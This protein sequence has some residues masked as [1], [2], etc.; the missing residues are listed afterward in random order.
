MPILY[1][2]K[3]IIRVLETHGFF[4]SQKGS[5]VK[6]KTTV[7]P[8]RPVIIPANRKVIPFGTFRSIVRQSGLTESDFLFVHEV[9]EVNF[10]NSGREWFGEALTIESKSFEVSI[11]LGSEAYC[12]NFSFR[13][14]SASLAISGPPG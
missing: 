13:A 8:I 1:S 4:V 10:R 6:M 11:G 3:Q 12:G 9:D 5:H 2:S 7:V 14:C